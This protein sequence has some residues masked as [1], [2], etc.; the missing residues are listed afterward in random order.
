MQHCNRTGCRKSLVA[1]F[2]WC[3]STSSD[4]PRLQQLTNSSS[5]PRAPQEG[6]V[7]LLYL[8]THLV[9]EEKVVGGVLLDFS[10]AFEAVP[11]RAP[12]G[13]HGVL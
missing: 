1:L 10:K 5:A 8:L 6:P 12:L 7:S 9:D 2:F 3:C 13:V 11:P 4:L